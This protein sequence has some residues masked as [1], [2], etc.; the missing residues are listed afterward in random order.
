[1][2]R[3]SFLRKWDGFR[4]QSK[5]SISPPTILLVSDII[6]MSPAFVGGYK[7]GSKPFWKCIRFFVALQFQE[8]WKVC[9][10]TNKSMIELH[11]LVFYLSR[12]L[13]NSD[14][15][16]WLVH[17]VSSS[18]FFWIPKVCRIILVDMV[19]TIHDDQSFKQLFSSSHSPR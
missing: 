13:W 11:I 8:I 7:L 18:I 10:Y 5:A 3:P 6:E 16:E 17:L 9:S 14:S 12:N 19:E 15:M 2:K 1:M 4:L